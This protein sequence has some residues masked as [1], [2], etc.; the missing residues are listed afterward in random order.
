VFAGFS[1]ETLASRIEASSS[2]FLVTADQ[3][4]RG[5]KQITLKDTV[6]AALKSLPNPDLIQTV[7]Y[8]RNCDGLQSEVTYEILHKDVRMNVLL[9]AQR[10]YCPCEVMDA[11][12]DLF[13][14][15]TS[16][17]TGKP[18]TG[19]PKG[20]VHTTAGDAL[21]AMLTSSIA[22]DLRPETNFACVADC[23]WITGHT[24]I[25]YGPLLNGCSTFIFESKP[26]YPDAGR[27]WDLIQRHQINVSYTSPTAI[28]SVKRYGDEIPNKYDL[29]SLRILGTVGEPI[30]PEAWL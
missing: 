7:V 29:S 3:G 24:Y 11:E 28:R 15:Y 19:K 6:N 13:I 18:T 10:P 8:E 1:S 20:L 26:L 4:V 23:G 14:L 27:Y 12:D 9:K 21:Y 17:S 16:G 2:R 22:F 25:T 30:N 5:G